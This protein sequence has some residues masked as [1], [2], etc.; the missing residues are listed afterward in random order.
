MSYALKI[1]QEEDLLFT[2]VTSRI[3]LMIVNTPNQLFSV[4]GFFS[5]LC[6]K[7]E[8]F[9]LFRLPKIRFC[10]CNPD[11]LI[12]I[13][14]ISTSAPL[15]TIARGLSSRGRCALAEITFASMHIRSWSTLVFIFT[16]LHECSTRT[17]PY[18]LFKHMVIIE[19]LLSS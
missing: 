12:Y 11:L 7:N 3:C 14:I 19:P 10:Y 13:F 15:V 4:V 18:V 5:P 17:V 2:R 9:F 6:F 1:I 16:N 8:N